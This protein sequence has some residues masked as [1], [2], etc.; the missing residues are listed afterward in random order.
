MSSRLTALVWARYQNGAGEML[1][2]LALAD[3]CTDTGEY[4]ALDIARLAKKTRQAERTVREQLRSMSDAG[5][6]EQME[7][8]KAFRISHA[9][10]GGSAPAAAP[11]KDDGKKVAKRAT[12]LTDEWDLPDEWREWALSEFPAW[13]GEF[14]AKVAERFRDH[15]ISASGQQASKVEWSGTWRNWCRREPAVPGQ[16]SGASAGQSAGEWWRSAS[17]IDKKGNELGLV[18]MDGEIWTQ[19]RDR[20][21]VKA[22]DGPWLK[23]VYQAPDPAAQGSFKAAGALSAVLA[24]LKKGNRSAAE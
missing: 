1:L 10:Q 23:L 2:A 13:T 7:G 12:R 6:L 4:I 19:W 16:A 3:Q 15:W 21:L 5:W 17:A 11:A 22:G 18:R 8:S 24:E 20:V 9:W 14:V